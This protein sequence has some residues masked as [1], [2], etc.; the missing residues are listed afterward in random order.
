[1]TALHEHERDRILRGEL[2]WK[3]TAKSTKL[4]MEKLKLQIK[5]FLVPRFW[6]SFPNNEDAKVIAVKM[7]F[8]QLMK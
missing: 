2:S 3:N 1:M 5:R 4:A 7:K 8:D 6:K